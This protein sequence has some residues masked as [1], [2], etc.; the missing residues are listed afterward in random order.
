MEEQ[1]LEKGDKIYSI[2]VSIGRRTKGDKTDKLFTSSDTKGRVNFC[3]YIAYVVIHK[4]QHF[5]FLFWNQYWVSLKPNL[6]GIFIGWSSI[7]VMFVVPI[8][9]LLQKQEIP[10]FKKLGDLC[11][12]D[13]EQLFFSVFLLKFSLCST[14]V[15]QKSLYDC[16]CF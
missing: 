6:V 1:N 7:K 11:F 2:N 4:L 13:V 14:F 5:K 3:H 16:Y 8:G 10:S 9:N 12:S 15:C